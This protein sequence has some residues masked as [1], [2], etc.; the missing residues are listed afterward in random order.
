[1]SVDDLTLQLS[2]VNKS[3]VSKKKKITAPFV[4]INFIREFCFLKGILGSFFF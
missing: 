3:F 4:I 1:M 2:L